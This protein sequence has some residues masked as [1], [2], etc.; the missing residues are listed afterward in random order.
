MIDGITWEFEKCLQGDC[1]TGGGVEEIEGELNG[2]YLRLKPE[3][4]LEDCKG[5]GVDHFGK[6]SFF[7]FLFLWY[8]NF[9]TFLST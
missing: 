3:L 7:L 8:P 6:S 5:V 2:N 4:R 9:A 1:E